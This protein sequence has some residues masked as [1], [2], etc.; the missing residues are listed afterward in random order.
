VPSGM[1]TSLLVQSSNK[2]SQAATC[3]AE[4]QSRPVCLLE[5]KTIY[6]PAF[7]TRLVARCHHFCCVVARW[8]IRVGHSDANPCI[9]NESRRGTGSVFKVEQKTPLGTLPLRKTH[10]HRQVAKG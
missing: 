2:L 6:K 10:I 5:K 3:L 4:K 9:Q 8:D 7:E 1:S